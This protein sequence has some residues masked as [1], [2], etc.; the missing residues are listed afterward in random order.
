MRLRLDNTL[1]CSSHDAEVE[2]HN[3]QETNPKRQAEYP[4]DQVCVHENSRDAEY[5]FY[6]KRI[7]HNLVN[8]NNEMERP[9]EGK[10]GICKREREDEN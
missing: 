3:C 4:M 6:G 8:E 7:W 1:R 9:I 2:Q 10:Q 5:D